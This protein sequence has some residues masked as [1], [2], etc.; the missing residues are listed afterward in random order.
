M[1][2][3]DRIKWILPVII[4]VSFFF[5]GRGNEQDIH[6]VKQSSK[7]MEKKERIEKKILRTSQKKSKNIAKKT[8]RPP[9]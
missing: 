7:L 6:F 4:L 3:G 1:D 9:K 8:K 5:Y 2:A